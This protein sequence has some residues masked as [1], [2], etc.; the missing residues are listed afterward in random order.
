MSCEIKL[1]FKSK[2]EHFTKVYLRYFK[3]RFSRSNTLSYRVLWSANKVD[4]YALFTNVEYFF[5]RIAWFFIQKNEITIFSLCW[6]KILY[7]EEKAHFL[8]IFLFYEYLRCWIQSGGSNI[9]YFLFDFDC[10]IHN[11]MYFTSLILGQLLLLCF[12][13]L[14]IL[15]L[16]PV[17]LWHSKLIA[18]FF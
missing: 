17:F 4:E 14:I 2:R 11:I 1:K 16:I 18:I 5:S 6:I 12:D 7:I 3:M 13:R 9:Y 15:L 10:N 8:Q